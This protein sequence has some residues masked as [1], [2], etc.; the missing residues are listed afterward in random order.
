MWG[1]KDESYLANTHAIDVLLSMLQEYIESNSHFT[2]KRIHLSSV[3]KFT[4]NSVFEKS[5]IRSDLRTKRPR[6][7]SFFQFFTFNY[8]N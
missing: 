6:M 3:L 4:L 5:C 8:N 2:N 1:Q 7:E